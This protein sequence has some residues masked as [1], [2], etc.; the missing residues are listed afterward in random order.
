[1]KAHGLLRRNFKNLVLVSAKTSKV[2]ECVN[3][4]VSEMGEKN[5]TID[6]WI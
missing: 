3:P 2:P 6:F 1:M 5:E 4:G